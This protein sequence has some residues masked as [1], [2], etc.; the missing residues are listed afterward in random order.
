MKH[1]TPGTLTFSFWIKLSLMIITVFYTKQDLIACNNPITS[2]PHSTNFESNSN[3]DWS[4]ESSVPWIIDEGGT[5]SSNTG[6]SSG[7]F[8][9]YYAY[10]EASSPNYPSVEMDLV[11]PCYYAANGS[12]ITF[13]FAY[14]MYGASIGTLSVQASTDGSNWTT[15]WSR[16]GDQGNNWFTA[17]VDLS[18]YAGSN[19]QIR[20]HGVTADSW[21]GDIAID[22]LVVSVSQDICGNGLDDDN[23]GMIDCGDLE[24]TSCATQDCTDGVKLISYGRDVATGS[25]G[26]GIPQ[27]NNFYIP[28]G[29]NRV[30][31]IAASFERSH[32]Q[33]GDNCN[34][35]NTAGTGLGDNFADPDHL[36]TNGINSQ[37]DIQA[38]GSGGTITKDNSL[39]LPEGD[40]R[41]MHQ[42][43]F[44]S[45]PDPNI[46]ASKISHENYFFALF[47]EEIDDLLGGAA[48]GTITISLPDITTPKDASD[49][50]LISAFTF[51]N[52]AQTNDGIVR[53]G[54]AFETKYTEGTP[55]NYTMT[56]WD[57]DNGQEP[58]EPEDGILLIATSGNDDYGFNVPSSFTQ[59]YQEK[60]VNN[61][62][63]NYQDYNEPD[64]FTYQPMFGN[65]PSS[66]VM[67]SL[68]VQSSGPSGTTVNGGM[69]GIFKI[70]SCSVE[71]ICDNGIDDNGDGQIDENDEDCPSLCP[72]GTVTVEMWTGISGTA[73]SD[74]TSN[75][76]YPDNPT[77]TFSYSSLDGANNIADNYGLRIRGYITPQESGYFQFNLTGDDD[78]QFFLSPN[79]GSEDKTMIGSITGWTGD[80]EHTKYSSQTSEEIYLMEG[81][82]Y[83]FEVLNKEGSGGD[84]VQVFWKTPSNNNWNIIGSQYLSPFFCAD[85][86]CDNGIDDDGDGSIDSDDPDCYDCT[87]GILINPGFDNDLNSWD[88]YGNTSVVAEVNGNKYARVSGGAGGF[89]Q[90]AVVEEG[91]LVTL[92]FYGKK[93]GIVSFNAG[94][95]FHDASLNLIGFE[96]DVQVNTDVFQQYTVSFNAPANAAYV[97]AFAYKDDTGG[98]AYLDGFCLTEQA[99]ICD[100]GIDDDGD[101]LIDCDDPNCP[102]LTDAGII[103]GDEE[104]CTAYNGGII[105][106]ATSPT[107]S[108]VITT[109]WESSTDSTNWNTIS[110]A[111]GF[112]YDPGTISQTTYFRRVVSIPGCSITLYSNVITKTVD[113]TK[114]VCLEDDG[115]QFGCDPS[116]ATTINGTGIKGIT[117]PVVRVLN[118]TLRDYYVAEVTFEGGANSPDYVTFTT[119]N[120]Q[121]RLVN[122]TY[123]D[124]ESGTNGLRYFRTVLNPADSVFVSHNGDTNLGES[125]VV[126][127]FYDAVNYESFGTALHQRIQPG[128]SIKVS[129]PLTAGINEKNSYNTIA[130]AGLED[131][132]SE[133][134]IDV[135]AD[136]ASRRDTVTSYSVGNSLMYTYPNLTGISPDA[137]SIHIEITSPST[138]GQDAFMTGFITSRVYCDQNLVITGETDHEGCVAEGDTLTYTYTVYNFADVEF[139]NLY[140]NSSLSGIIQFNASNTIAANSQLTV[141][142]DYVITADDLLNIP[143]VNDVTVYGFNSSFGI[144]PKNDS[145]SG[146]LVIC[147]IC[148][149][150]VDDDQDGLTDCEDPDCFNRV[151]SPGVLDQPFVDCP[152]NDPT[153]IESLI[154]PFYYCNQISNT[155]F[156]YGTDEFNLGAY[157]GGSATL[158]VDN[159]NKLSGANSGKITINS[160]G[161]DYYNV[162]V[163][164][165]GFRV[166]NDDKIRVSFDARA[167]ANKNIE[168]ALQLREAPWTVYWTQ[169]IDLTTSSQS[170]LFDNIELD[171]F[172]ENVGLV[173]KVGGDATDMYLDN[174]DYMIECEDADVTYI[175][176]RRSKAGASDNFTSWSTIS[177]ATSATYDPPVITEI[178]QY[179]RRATGLCSTQEWSNIIEVSDCPEPFMCDGKF[180]QTVEEGGEYYLYEIQAKPTVTRTQIFNLNDAGIQGGINSAF[181]DK[182][183]GYIYVLNMEAPFGLYRI[184][185]DQKI[186]RAD[187][188]KGFPK[189]AFVNAADKSGS[190]IVYRNATDSDIYTLDWATMMVSKTCDFPSTGD[191]TDNIGDLAFNPI[192]GLLYGTRD[193]S[194]IIV[195]IDL[196][197]CTMNTITASETFETANGAFFIAADGTAYGYENGDGQFH[198]INLSTGEVQQVGSGTVTT[199]TDGCSCDGIKFTKEVLQDTAYSCDSYT[200]KFTFYNEWNAA[201]S[202]VSFTDTLLNNLYWS[203]EPENLTGGIA[204]NS[205][206]ITGNAIGD[207]TINTIPLGESSFTITV[208]VPQTYDGGAVYYNQAYLSSLPALLATKKASEYPATAA[209]EDATPITIIANTATVTIT[210][211]NEICSGE[212]TVLT[213]S[214][215]GASAP[216]SYLWSSGATGSSTAFSPGATT[217]ASVT[218]TDAMGCTYVENYTINVSNDLSATIDVNGGAC[219]NE[220]STLSAIA[221]GGASPYTY[222]WTGPNGFTAMDSV[223]TISESGNYYLTITDSYGCT[224]SV[225]AYIYN[226]YTVTI[227]TLSTEVCEG[228]SVNLNINSSSAVSY[229]W[230]P[231]AGNATGSSVTVTPGVPSTTYAVTVTNNQGCS[232]ETTITI[233]AIA[234]PIVSI[235]GDDLLCIGETTTLSPSTGGTWTSNNPAVAT[236]SNSGVVTAISG[237]ST[238]FTFEHDT[239]GCV[240]DPTLPITIHNEDILTDAGDGELCV[241]ETTTIATSASGTFYSSDTNVVTVDNAGL[242]TAI[243]NGFAQI[244]FVNDNTSCETALAGGI[245]VHDVP[246]VYV[247]GPTD[248]CEGETTSLYPTVG[249]TWTSSNTSIATV[250]SNGTVTAITPGTVSF[251]FTSNAGC[252]SNSTEDITINPLANVSISGPTDIC[253]GSYSELSADLVGTW[254]SSDPSIASVVNGNEI[255]GLAVGEVTFTFTTTTSCTSTTSDTLHVFENTPV[256]IAGPSSVCA[257]ST[258]DLDASAGTGTWTSSNNALATVDNNGIVTGVSSGTVIIYYT[259]PAESCLQNAQ[260][261][262]TIQAK[263]T[264]VLGG[265]DMIC[266][267]GNTFFTSSTSGTWSSDNPSIATITSSGI[268]T[269]QSGGSTV[270]YFENS[271]GCVS[272]A[273]VAITISPTMSP[274]IDFNGSVCLTDTSEL[275][276][277]V[278]GGI[279]PFEYIWSG[280]NGFSSNVQTIGI[281][282]DG[283][284]YVTITDNA[285]CQVNTS[286]FVYEQYD[287]F[288]FTLNS[289]VCEGDDVTLSV[290]NPDAIGYQWSANAG[291]STSSSVTVTPG[292]PSESYSVTVT[293]DQGC[294]TS[295]TAN[296]DVEPSPTV[297]VVGS[298]ILCVNETSTLSPTTGGTWV[299]SN[300]SIASVTNNG[301]VTAKSGGSVTFTFTSDNGCESDPTT[302][303]TVVQQADVTL[304][305][306]NTLCLGQSVTATSTESGFWSSSNPSVASVNSSG[307][308]SSNAQGTAIITFYELTNG[309]SGDED[310]VIT[311]S[312]N[313]STTYIGPSTVCIGDTSEIQ[314]TSGGTWTSSNPSIASIDNNGIIVSHASGNVTFTYTSD[315]G[316]VSN[317]SGVFTVSNKPN[318]FLPAD[319]EIC[320]GTQL[321]ITPSSGGTWISTD[322]SIATINNNGQITAVGPGEVQFIFT[323]TSTGCVSDSS[324]VLTII[325]GPDTYVTG[326][327]TICVGST[328]TLHP[329]TGGVWTSSNSAIASVTNAGVVTAHNT[330]YV[331]FTFNDNTTGCES[332][333]K[334]FIYIEPK[335]LVSYTGPSSLCIGETTSVSPTTGGTW[336]SSNP[337]VASITNAGIVT[338]HSAGSVSLTFTS[339]ELSCSS[340]LNTNLVVYSTPEIE[341]QGVSEIC[342]GQ[343]TTFTPTSGGIWY[344]NNSSIASITSDGIVTGNAIGTTTFY[345]VESGTGCY[346]QNSQPITVVNKPT[347]S[348]TGPTSICQDETTTLSPTTGGSWVSNN[349]N[350][351]TVTEDGIVTGVGSGVAKFVFTSDGG[352]V[353]NYTAPVVVYPK[354]VVSLNGNEDICLDETIQIQPSSG[355]LWTS[356]NPSVAVITNT[357]LITGMSPGIATFTYHDTTSGCISDPTAPLTIN[358]IPE[359]SIIGPNSICVGGSTTLAPTVGGVWISL[360]PSIATIEND[361]TVTGASAGDVRFIFI[362]NATSCYSDTSEVVTVISGSSIAFNGPT[363]IC[364]GDTTY[365]TPTSNGTWESSKPTVAS[366][367]DAGLIIGLK[368]GSAKFRFHDNITGCVSEWSTTLV[369]NGPPTVSVDGSSEICIGTTT[370]LMPSNGGSWES[371]D[372]AIATVSNSGIVTGVAAGTAYFTYTDSITGCSTDGNLSVDVDA[373][374]EVAILGNKEICI[375]YTTQ[376]SPNSGGIWISSNTKIATVT[377]TGIVTGKGPGKVTFQFIDAGSGCSASGT[378]DTI[379]VESC[380]NNDF[381]VAQISQVITGD[382]HTN[383]NVVVETEYSTTP[384]LLSKPSGSIANLT[385]NADGT[386]TFSANKKGKYI[387]KTPVCVPPAVIN[388]YSSLLEITVLDDVYAV[389]SAVANMEHVSTYANADPGLPGN[390][391]TINPLANDKCVYSGGCELDTASL[392]IVQG[393]GSGTANI[394]PNGTITYQ[395]DAGHIGLDTII[396]TICTLD[397]TSCSTTKQ[398]IITRATS[399]N[400]SVDAADDFVYTYKAT[401]VSANVM[402]NDSDPEGKT[403]TTIPQGNESSPIVLT[404]GEYYLDNAGNLAFIPSN[405]FTGSVDIAY[406]TCDSDGQCTNATAHVMVLSEMTVHIRLYLEG[407]LMFNNN[408]VG[409]TGKPLMRDNLRSNPFTGLNDIPVEDPYTTSFTTYP[410]VPI[411]S[412]FEK[413]GPGLLPVNQTIQ[414]PNAVFAVEGEN[415]IVDWVFVEL[416]S[417]DN[418]L[419]RIGTRSGLVQRDGD[420]VDLDGV[421]PLGF[422]GVSA[423][424]FYVVVRHRNH[425]GA[426]SMLVANDDVV[427]FT[428]PDMPVFNFGTTHPSGLDFTGLSLNYNVK[429]GYAALWA[430]D[431]NGDGVIKYVGGNVDINQLY[432]ELLFA[433]A[434]SYLSNYND[435]F[436]YSQGDYNLNGKIKFTNPDD[437]TNLLYAQIILY[438]LNTNLQANF[439][440]FIEQVPKPE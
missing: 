18:S 146:T 307:V 218:I 48:S 301:V 72:P 231:N 414:N 421:S 305:G 270:F 308:I 246:T 154:D 10:M 131:N 323:L 172:S 182:S 343:T 225:S 295:A 160:I 181:F 126:Y 344:S 397:G 180:Y 434:P 358:D 140:A 105:I 297:S 175:W 361:G 6:P 413:V 386:Y 165:Q 299:S 402:L 38:S 367:T 143:L 319:T 150:G 147:E 58:D 49:E 120:G 45:P 432:Q 168:V 204:I 419:Q 101:G 266:I 294:A 406:T 357:G 185:S 193:N 9:T 100:N 142:V 41:L 317:P 390:I 391:V 259:N 351:A 338:A 149:N 164:T 130:I 177:G 318:I 157:N 313:P 24:C 272:D 40:L 195:E 427:D 398:K 233:G 66:G 363:E 290:N 62:S 82:V 407:A 285:G 339:N 145:W 3:G 211:D 106:D 417:K 67:N 428:D 284:Y 215:T 151:L 76:N 260:K 374:I 89:G 53:A 291:S 54:T 250:S 431:F 247:S 11:S 378:T 128:E 350:V 107:Y 16:S 183:S 202:N 304:N 227:A 237:G 426:M 59:V 436:G 437:D 116:V 379:T 209:I 271:N 15:L 166:E 35:D 223:T 336:V 314:P 422:A 236:V 51:I 331:E 184:G 155:E 276:A 320:V 12:G 79:P 278:T 214:I 39:Y 256:S 388:C 25:G 356:S 198:E 207:F 22:N 410:S 171:V 310:I 349:T 395:P 262:I 69:L 84:H 312:A 115:W 418:M 103:S 14:H 274:I 114:S 341:L 124:G 217:N 37:I 257:G 8:S 104:N 158:T 300:S 337:A 288:I 81:S 144:K 282:D 362:D 221:S 229:Q 169:S 253:V 220:N 73:I 148:D 32:C 372:E 21:A 162:E 311:V 205:S 241:G 228:E 173:F 219:F 322:P 122:K 244:Y 373:D 179:R 328:T 36:A 238:T 389:N 359:I 99:E 369:V 111:N 135:Y 20:M 186:Q 381:N 70:E 333:N 95:S 346:S 226:E 411:V 112:A 170:F 425:L 245:T 19:F 435:A 298:D 64:G 74:L 275:T 28:E 387:Y 273:S 77:Y 368:Q 55:A 303:V 57:F 83:Y 405:T 280:P 347:V 199:Q 174:V 176:Q 281:N 206:S 412:N 90:Y 230:G 2:F 123:Y 286:A 248:I 68:T 377:N 269:G 329:T 86:I 439:A 254:T 4:D 239:T 23:D 210:G 7:Y 119:N 335:P 234:K 365:I 98:E 178:V 306:P 393:P 287:P 91:S 345:F 213:A 46:P 201:L 267:G 330:G 399:A 420:V 364:V 355:G 88:N 325:G 383:D 380:I 371:S 200:Y 5:A 92:T 360:D 385:I 354:P 289:A 94:I 117:D 71:E 190:T 342:I 1:H 424:S 34:N 13:D 415:A 370:Q 404:E 203:S 42:Y 47:E 240:S 118:P 188:V 263:P 27:L 222:S 96:V 232:A 366:I 108:G 33:G 44:P 352:C 292:I 197:T 87:D 110:G 43:L 326:N 125:M 283:N 63:N 375:G 309:C 403:I 348:I 376:L 429:Y 302:S 167:D 113:P 26:S 423:D 216:F 196:A 277:T 334:P 293:N 31:F 255:I 138:N 212:A 133:I 408:A 392:V 80:Y 353:S 384:T 258:I 56:C 141:T 189:D 65:G 235:T 60:V 264:I 249:G 194:D 416:R 396:Y 252:A 61:A 321:N 265:E 224:E 127:A 163:S 438:P 102:N 433:S 52:A 315:F 268:V 132:G 430:G 93:S 243:D 159:T 97:K 156:D 382:I 75:G 121:T 261:E 134:Y 139:T 296:I 242:V 191:D 440:Y 340:T 153:L 109:Y 85:E 332:A 187:N 137:D 251:I 50:A 316:C 30:V 327:D 401:P 29:N 394:L 152:D 129:Y 78:S 192:N 208:D 324:N 279:A 409:S 161:P 400:N 136:G 17:S